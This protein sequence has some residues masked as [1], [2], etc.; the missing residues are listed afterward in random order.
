MSG[1]NYS[2]ERPSPRGP[3]DAYRDD[4]HRSDRYHDV[5]DRPI[6]DHDY[7]RD[8]SNKYRDVRDRPVTNEDYENHGSD[9]QHDSR[10]NGARR[11]KDRGNWGSRSFEKTSSTNTQRFN[12]NSSSPTAMTTRVTKKTNVI[13]SESDGK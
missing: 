1:R 13:G 5:R 9:R 8:S 12:S 2:D 7:E 11:N 3:V 6:D 10:D 4:R